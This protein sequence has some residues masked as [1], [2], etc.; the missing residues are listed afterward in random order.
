M[1]RTALLLVMTVATLALCACQ[2]LGGTAVGAAGTGAAYEYQH[3]RALER[4]E[5]RFARGEIDRDEY[6]RRKREIEKGSLV[7]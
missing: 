4:L 3:K 2:F 5:E 1:R 6:L 7:Y